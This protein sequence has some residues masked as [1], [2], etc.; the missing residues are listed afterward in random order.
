MSSG[1]KLTERD[2]QI[3]SFINA[4][5]CCEMPQLDRRFGLSKP[6]NYQLM[7]RLLKA[8]LVKHE[9]VFYGR[10][11]IYRLTAK[12]AKLTDLPPLA[13]IPLAT[14]HHD[15]TLIELYLRLRERY[16]QA[17]W[18]SERALM[19]DKHADGVGKRGHLPDGVLI[20]PEQ[21]PIAVEVELTLKSKPR[22]ERILKGYSA[23]FDYQAVWYYCS[24]A[25]AA[26]IAPMTVKLPFIHIHRLKDWL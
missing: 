16:P 3:L 24:E 11:G 7:N 8:G 17:H 15:L 14:Y 1:F 10:H 12:G 9:R 5:G 4:F 19:R 20:L 26:Y 21:K 18:M 23:A 6:R 22:L 2:L 13:R 25:V